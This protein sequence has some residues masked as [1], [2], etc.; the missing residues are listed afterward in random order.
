MSPPPVAAHSAHVCT[1]R[2]VL[3]AACLAPC[4]SSV[5]A[6][7]VNSETRRKLALVL[8]DRVAGAQF[9]LHPPRM[10]LDGQPALL[11]RRMALCSVLSMAPLLPPQRAH[12]DTFL[13]AGPCVPGVT[14]ERCRGVFWETGK[15]YKKDTSDA[16]PS[17]DEYLTLLATLRSLRK[18]LGSRDL[19]D[20]A[21][22]GDNKEV[23]STASA[24]RAEI[25][26]VGGQACR[27]LNEEERYDAEYRLNELL[28]LLDDLDVSALRASRCRRFH[29]VAASSGVLKRFDEFLSGLPEKASAAT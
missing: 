28:L 26:R 25:R 15:L 10:I 23:G 5:G 11:S 29:A 13:R 18:S 4:G 6:R 17:A 8:S 19:M 22:L 12:A 3:L 14:A 16:T 7:T 2:T 24:A 20:L 9:V 27:A 21:D 1:R